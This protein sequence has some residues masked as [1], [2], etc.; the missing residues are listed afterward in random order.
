M[1]PKTDYYGRVFCTPDCPAYF[2]FE[3]G[4]A[5]CNARLRSYP[6][7]WDGEKKEYLPLCKI[8]KEF[9]LI[10]NES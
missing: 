4:D 8:P 9:S 10:K 1:Y 7:K 6:D 3:D 2:I 5:A